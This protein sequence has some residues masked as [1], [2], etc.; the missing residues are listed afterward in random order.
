MDT[1]VRLGR[2]GGGPGKGVRV[3][4]DRVDVVIVGAGLAGLTAAVDLTDAGLEVLVLERSHRVGGRVATDHAHGFTLDRGFQVLNTAYP[5]VRRR[6]DLDALGF[7]PFTSGA[8]VRHGNRLHRVPG[9]RAGP[10]SLAAAPVAGPFPPRAWGQLAALGLWSARTGGLP[11]KHVKRWPD[12]PAERA[13]IARGVSGTVLE[14]FVRPF[15]SGV[16][17]DDRLE[18]SSRF[19]DLVWRSFVRGTVGVPSGGMAAI[20]A[21]LARRLP[22]GTVRSGATVGTVRPGRVEHDGG[23]VHA[24]AVLVAADP[25]TAATLL[26]MPHTPTMRALTTYYHACEDSPLAE[27]TL[28]LDGRPGRLVANSTVMTEAAQAYSSDGRALVATTVV[29]APGP[30]EEVVRRAVAD[31]YGVASRGWEPVRTVQVAQALPAM[32]PG[33]PLRRPVHLGE[34]LFVAGDH[35]DTPSSQG[36]MAS[37]TRAARA[38]RRHL[39]GDR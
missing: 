38:V 1:E 20:P 9:S 14:R 7:A 39:H 22:A 11:A 13:L 36:A 17:A 28:V 32:P 10:A 15:L 4:V 19:V 33:R 21:Q 8:L 27:P 31:L 26:D 18:T 34:M 6:L 35:R 16:L 5:Q 2:A 37:G 12:R 30:P 25:T 3:S 29:G 24:R 23:S